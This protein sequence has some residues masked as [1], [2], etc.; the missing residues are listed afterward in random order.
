MGDQLTSDIDGARG[1]GINPVLLDRDGNHNGIRDCPRIES[2]MELPALL[3]LVLGKYPKEG[4]SSVPPTRPRQV[5]GGTPKPPPKRAQPSLDSL[6][7]DVGVHPP[8]L[9]LA[10]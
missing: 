1:V 5:W 3:A 7:R 2:L 4:S 6:T 8:A 10:G 9:V